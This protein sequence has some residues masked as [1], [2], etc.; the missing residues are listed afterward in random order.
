MLS[1]EQ[2]FKIVN[3]WLCNLITNKTKLYS[4][5]EWDKFDRGR[6]CNEDEEE[7]SVSLCWVH[8]RKKRTTMMNNFQ[9]CIYETLRTILS[10]L[11]LLLSA[12]RR[13]FQPM[14]QIMPSAAMVIFDNGPFHLILRLSPLVLFSSSMCSPRLHH[15]HHH[16]FF[17]LS[18]STKTQ[19]TPNTKCTPKNKT[20]T[21]LTSSLKPVTKLLKNQDIRKW[22]GQRVAR[23]SRSLRSKNNNKM[24]LEIKEVKLVKEM[25]ALFS[26]DTKVSGY[27]C[28]RW[29]YSQSQK[30]YGEK[31]V[32]VDEINRN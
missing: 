7:R 29:H 20:N 30:A 28:G 26:T 6:T 12:T 31:E 14:S 9:I 25:V 1:Q 11:T 23:W 10:P 15:L 13:T 22:H 32:R 16:P 24:R 3:T 21:T 2:I 19:T 27:C 17:P 18:S 5:K 4:V 8:R